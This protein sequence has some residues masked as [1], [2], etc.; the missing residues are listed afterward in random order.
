MYS[1]QLFWCEYFPNLHTCFAHYRYEWVSHQCPDSSHSEGI[2]E[3][4]THPDYL[5]FTPVHCAP[6]KMDKPNMDRE[7]KVFLP[8][9]Q[10]NN[11]SNLLN[12]YAT[13]SENYKTTQSD[14][15]HYTAHIKGFVF[16]NMSHEVPLICSNDNVMCN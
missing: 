10:S 12:K 15:T 4:P 6:Y 16:S 5:D 14:C 8:S 1:D 11:Q 2:N 3:I 13:L 9:L 7:K